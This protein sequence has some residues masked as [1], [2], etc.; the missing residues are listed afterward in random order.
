ML[1]LQLAR[2]VKVISKRR[3]CYLKVGSECRHVLPHLPELFSHRNAFL[4]LEEWKKTISI[5]STG[6]IFIG[7]N[8]W[9][10]W[11]K[12]TTQ[13]WGCK[14]GKQ[15][16]TAVFFWAAQMAKVTFVSVR[17]RIPMQGLKG[18]K[19][20]EKERGWGRHARDSSQ[21][22]LQHCMC[23]C[24]CVCVCI[25]RSVHMFVWKCVSI[26]GLC[27]RPT[28][29]CV[30]RLRCG[31]QQT[32]W[33]NNGCHLSA[34]KGSVMDCICIEVVDW[35]HNKTK[36]I[37]STLTAQKTTKPSLPNRAQRAIIVLMEY[38]TFSAKS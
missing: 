12:P 23:V 15:S 14:N 9:K 20:W 29:V 6:L 18:V 35:Q 22:L 26:F 4:L 21:Q 27:V 11:K 2:P 31:A 17:Q 3:W 34:W 30:L 36:D 33:R 5:H 37:N 13:A 25:F 8:G 38:F 16:C 32:C 19:E 10:W 7:M 24:V 1:F 28:V